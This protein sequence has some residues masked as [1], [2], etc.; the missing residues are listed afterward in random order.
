[1]FTIEHFSLKKASEVDVDNLPG[2][3]I[4]KVQEI[5]NLDFSDLVTGDEEFNPETN[6]ITFSQEWGVKGWWFGSVDFTD[7]NKV[8][9]EY[10]DCEDSDSTRVIGQDGKIEAELNP[11]YKSV[12]KHLYLQTSE[13]GTIK[14]LKAYLSK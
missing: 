8:V 7:W 5:L 9:I 11:D 3:E 6:I 12:V 1:M 2:K 10:V 4:G 14:L 13:P